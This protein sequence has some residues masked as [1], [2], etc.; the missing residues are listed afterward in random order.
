M[1][2]V[3]KTLVFLFGIHNVKRYSKIP[4]FDCYLQMWFRTAR[5]SMAVVRR[6]TFT[7]WTVVCAPL[8]WQLPEL[9]SLWPDAGGPCV[10]PCVVVGAGVMALLVNVTCVDVDTCGGLVVTA[11]QIED[12][13]I[14]DI[15]SC[16]H[17][18]LRSFHGV[19][20]IWICNPGL[21]C[22]PATKAITCLF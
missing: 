10:V 18:G 7:P 11:V 21:T 8:H 6:Y 3:H 5:P 20:C 12:T 14:L 2:I 4:S 22:L 1:H 13:F 15:Y 19:Q 17:F 9:A 16:I